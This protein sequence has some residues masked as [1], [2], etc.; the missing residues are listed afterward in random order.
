MLNSPEQVLLS[1]KNSNKILLTAKKNADTD[2][3][4][5]LL[6]LYIILKKLRK[7]AQII[8]DTPKIPL[9]LKFLPNLDALLTPIVPM[10]KFIISLDITQNKIDEFTYDIAENRLNIYLTP[11]NGSFDKSMVSCSSGNFKYDLAIVVDTQDIEHLGS[12]FEN[13]TEFFYK[14][15]VIN[16]DHVAENTRFGQVHHIDLTATSTTE[17]IYDLFFPKNDNLL[18]EPM[19]TTLLTGIIAKTKSFKTPQITPKTLN[20]VSQLL[21]FGARRDDI[22]QNLYRTKSLETLKLWGKVLLGLQYDNNL[23][24]A[25]TRIERADFENSGAGEETLEEMIEEI[26]NCSPQA[27]IIHLAWQ[28]QEGKN[29]SLVYSDYFNTLDLT[30]PLGPKGT[31]QTCYIENETETLSV[32]M[33]KVNAKIKQSLEA[34]P[35]KN[36]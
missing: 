5:S 8:L 14:T 27:Q 26:L 9:R 7:D 15:P 3:I 34:L 30:K 1:I 21:G 6:S 19:A 10:N 32:W 13:N 22:I 35:A 24:L 29:K 4:A 18:D 12:V 20:M 33:D 16:I 36:R 25:W 28:K 17:V 11:K 23:K 2:T 31:K